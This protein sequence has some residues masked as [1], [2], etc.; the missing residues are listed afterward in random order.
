MRG[1]YRNQ[2]ARSAMLLAAALAL[3]FFAGLES[4]VAD[5]ALL[6]LWPQV[7]QNVDAAAGRIQDRIE[8]VIVLGGIVVERSRHIIAGA[9][10][11]CAVGAGVGATAAV[12]LG[13]FTGGITLAGVPA[14]SAVGC[15][16]GGL[17]GASFG[18]PL[19]RYAWD[20]D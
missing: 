6:R 5:F 12:G 8:P 16:I 13:L 15:G 18:Y 11:G 17:G 9:V 19:D 4:R 10:M 3:V 1:L 14:A 20:W 7:A 2:P